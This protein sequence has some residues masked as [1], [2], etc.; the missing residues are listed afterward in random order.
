M[1]GRLMCTSVELYML[2]L[3]AVAVADACPVGHVAP[4]GTS[5][6]AGSARVSNDLPL[7]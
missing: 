5:K 1:P 7:R 2:S 3:S 6:E 4:A